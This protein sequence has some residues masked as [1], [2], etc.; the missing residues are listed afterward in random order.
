MNSCRS[1]SAASPTRRGTWSWRSR[2]QSL[3]R[4]KNPGNKVK[5]YVLHFQKK[6]KWWIQ[7]RALCRVLLVIILNFLFYRCRS[8]HRR[9]RRA[10][11]RSR[12]RVRHRGSRNRLLRRGRRRRRD[13]LR[14]QTSWKKVVDHF[15]FFCNRSCWW[16]AR[17]FVVCINQKL[18]FFPPL[19]P[20]G[21]MP[22]SFQL[23]ELFLERIFQRTNV[24]F[25]F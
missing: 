2:S 24:I 9:S 4:R 19:F 21:P 18:P 23:L 16:T 22:I 6:L 25:T 17:S 20:P 14:S 11:T 10:A 3:H 13:I 12:S 5:R 15:F 8:R 1:T 7:C